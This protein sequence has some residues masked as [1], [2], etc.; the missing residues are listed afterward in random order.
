MASIKCGNCGQT[1]DSVDRVR[2]CYLEKFADEGVKLPPRQTDPYADNPVAQMVLSKSD[3]YR[4]G[5]THGVR[6][7]PSEPLFTEDEPKEQDPEIVYIAIDEPGVSNRNKAG[8]T[9]PGFYKNEQ[10]IFK[11]TPART[12]DR[13]FAHQLLSL[14][15]EAPEWTYMGLGRRFIGEYDSKL[16]L[17][18]AKEFGHAYGHCLICGRLLTAEQSV[19][20]GIGPICA[21]K[22]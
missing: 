4:E 10:G 7:A 16:T 1:H 5:R 12:S 11:V 2:L 18:E 8:Q 20:D 6:F 9:K 17:E 15:Q 3:E 13:T 19:A 21:G 14:P 22:L